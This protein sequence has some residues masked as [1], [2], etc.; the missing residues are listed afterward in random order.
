[1]PDIFQRYIYEALR[2]NLNLNATAYIEDVLVYTDGSKKEHWGIVRSVL[3]KLEIAG[4]FLDIDKCEF[5][6]H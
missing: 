6:K 1:M 5:L 3:R 2:E 4:L